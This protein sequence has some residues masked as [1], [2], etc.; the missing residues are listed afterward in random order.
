VANYLEIQSMAEIQARPVAWLWPG[1][2]AR[3]KLTLLDGDPGAGKSWLSLAIATAVAHGAPFPIESERRGKGK[4]LLMSA[5]DDPADTIRGRLDAMGA[6]LHGIDVLRSTRIS[7][8]GRQADADARRPTWLTEDMEALEAA[9]LTGVGY[10]MLVVDPLNAYIPASIDSARDNAVRSALAPLAALAMRYGV[11][12]LA[13]RHLTKGSRD[14]AIYRGQGSIAYTAAA[15]I[16]LLAGQEQHNGRRRVLLPIKCNLDRLRGAV[17]YE[18]QDGRFAWL[19]AVDAKAGALLAPEAGEDEEN[20][21]EQVKQAVA[22]YLAD[23]RQPAREVLERVSRELRCSPRSVQRAAR[24]LHLRVQR[25]GFGPGSILYWQLGPSDTAISSLPSPLLDPEGPHRR[26]DP[27]TRQLSS[28]GTLSP[29]V[30]GSVFDGGLA[31]E[32][33]P[34][35]RL[36][37]LAINDYY[38]FSEEDTP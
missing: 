3:G 5:E 6:D 33:D 24:E 8:N 16:V 15:R 23:G 32:P 10:D 7:P 13:I 14:K 28:I 31:A 11:C 36:R 37:S 2:L 29:M 1:R 17:G 34:E 22:D 27:H 30:E 9:L 38:P 12:V 19:G 26:Q 20:L 18:I 21:R 4:V 35:E 25:Q